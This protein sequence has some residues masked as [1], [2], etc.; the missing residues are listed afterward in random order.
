MWFAFQENLLEII[1]DNWQ[2]LLIF[3]VIAIMVIANLL[4]LFNDDD[5]EDCPEETEEI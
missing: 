3:G 5:D 2:F 1:R 4:G